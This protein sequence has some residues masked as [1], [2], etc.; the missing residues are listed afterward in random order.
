MFQLPNMDWKSF[1]DEMINRA[2]EYI[3]IGYWDIKEDELTLWLSNFLSD[4]EKFFSS[5]LIYRIIYRNKYPR[6]SMYNYIINI[7]LPENLKKH[8]IYTIN[9]LEEFHNDLKHNPWKL[10]FK[11]STISEID[12]CASKS[13]FQILR[14]FRL[15]GSFHAK[16]EVTKQNIKN[17]D[18]NEIK[19][20][21]LFDDIMGS[22]EQFDTYIQSIKEE[23]KDFLFIYC[24]L[25]AHKDGLKLIADKNYQNILILPVEIIDEK[26]SFFH[27]CFSPKIA[28]NIDMKELEIFYIDFI[29]KNTKLKKD[30]LGK[31]NQALCYIFDMA[32]PNN[33]LPIFWYDEENK[34]NRIFPR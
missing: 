31:D 28:E 1:Y 10:H 33:T 24:P 18:K 6:L 17:L 8:N 7:L 3:R 23:A 27:N 12:E 11:F 2:K 5:L 16:L 30:L 13:G 26:Y 22:G 19:A 21:I 32:T 4:E 25:V 20:I 15:R 29:K 9:T 14:E 34:W